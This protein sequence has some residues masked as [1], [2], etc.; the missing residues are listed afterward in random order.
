MR[1]NLIIANPRN[2]YT[3]MVEHYLGRMSYIIC[4]LQWEHSIADILGQ[5]QVIQVKKTWGCRPSSRIT[6]EYVITVYLCNNGI[7]FTKEVLSF[8]FVF[9]AF[10]AILKKIF[11]IFGSF[12][13]GFILKDKTVAEISSSSHFYSP[14]SCCMYEKHVALPEFIMKIL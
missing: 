6:C 7:R 8:S 14:T 9:F 11:C 5:E 2:S 4:S 10:I 1:R 13:H 12:S 3:S